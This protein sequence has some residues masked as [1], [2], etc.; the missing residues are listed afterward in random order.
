MKG[1]KKEYAL[2]T[3][4][5]GGMG[6][7]FA[8]HLAAK[9][10]NLI[11]T[12]VSE[13]DLIK[14]SEELKKKYDV[15]V[16]TEAIDLTDNKQLSDFTKQIIK[17]D[18]IDMLVNCAGFGEGEMFY[19]EKIE[20]QL[21]M[22]QVHITATVQLVHSVLPGMIKHRRGNIITVSSMAAFMPAP[23]S[24]IYAGTKSFLNTFMETIHM[25]VHK[26]GIRVQSLCPGLT[27]T[28]FHDKLEKEGKRSKISKA[29]PWMDVDKVVRLSF[30]CLERGKVVCVPGCINKVMKKAVPIIPRKSFYTLS[31]KISEKTF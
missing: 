21:R 11:L 1:N 15:E 22:I 29:A 2:I 24:S 27:R 4:A 14:I 8:A 26:Y 19:K 25:E 3:G 30:K 18:D 9:K 7:T 16:K 10:H 13:T 12:D 28:G 6:R 17:Q 5:T 23:G 31:E 20:R